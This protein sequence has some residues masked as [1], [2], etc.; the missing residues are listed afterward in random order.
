MAKKRG[1]KQKKLPK[2]RQNWTFCE[3][4][5]SEGGKSKFSAG[6]RNCFCVE[7]CQMNLVTNPFN[8]AGEKH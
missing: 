5:C 1:Y 2:I 6:F 4:N 8:K 3:K 7:K